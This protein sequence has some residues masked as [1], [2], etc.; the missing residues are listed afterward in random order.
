MLGLGDRRQRYG[1]YARIGPHRRSQTK[2]RNPQG[3]AGMQK[4]T[5]EF[6]R[7]RARTGAMGG[8]ARAAAMTKKERRAS[9]LKASKAAAKARTA[10]ARRRS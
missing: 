3:K 1:G 7:T 9:A 2:R 6:K 5:L 10:K 8:F 4:I